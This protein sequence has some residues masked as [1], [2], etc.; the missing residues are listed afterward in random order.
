MNLQTL[1]KENSKKLIEIKRQKA[2]TIRKHKN[3]N[4]NRNKR[5]DRKLHVNQ[6]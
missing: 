4:R 3:K 1:L 6:K 5:S 2:K